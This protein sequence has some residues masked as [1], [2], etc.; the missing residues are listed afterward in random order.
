MAA[1]F[2]HHIAHL[3]GLILGFVLGIHLMYPAGRTV[4]R[5]LDLSEQIAPLL[6]FVIVFVGVFLAVLVLAQL[7]EQLIGAIN[8]TALNRVLGGMLGALEAV[9]IVSLMLWATDPYGWP[10][11]RARTRS[12]FVEPIEVVAQAA[13]TYTA[14]LWPEINRLSRE[15]SN[16]FQGN[17]VVTSRAGGILVSGL[18]R[19]M[20]RSVADELHN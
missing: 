16:D 1:G 6:G 2:V 5:V 11:D 13:W 17:R 4:T 3:A 7:L 19:A 20:L 12:V 18:D 10:D 14:E 9:L 15:L 8:L